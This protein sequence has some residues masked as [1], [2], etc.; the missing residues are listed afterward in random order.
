MCVDGCG[1]L[2]TNVVAV[3]AIKRVM[4][5]RPSHG[6]LGFEGG[7]MQGAT[8]ALSQQAMIMM[9]LAFLGGG[10]VQAT[11]SRSCLILP[12]AQFKK[13]F[14]YPF[15]AMYVMFSVL[16]PLPSHPPLVPVAGLGFRV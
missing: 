12:T 5:T 4:D 9:V 6:R 15:I 1:S 3:V 13:S 7:A 11:S 2:D 8:N 16:E 14:F 10:R